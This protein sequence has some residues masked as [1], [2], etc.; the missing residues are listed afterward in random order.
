VHALIVETRVDRVGADLAGMQLVPDL[1]EPHVV[2]APTQ[3]A[4][5]V[6]RGERGGLVQEEQLGEPAGLEQRRAM[7]SSEAEPATDPSLDRVP[8]ADPPIVVVKTAA[9]SV[10]EAAG[11]GRDQIAERRDPV[12]KGHDILI[13]DGAA[14]A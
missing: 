12:L 11:R 6:T 9:V 1:A 8:A 5:T 7:P 10:D 3:G 2:L 13:I 14:R 4:R